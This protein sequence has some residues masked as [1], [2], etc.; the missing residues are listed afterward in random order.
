MGSKLSFR[1][2]IDGQLWARVKIKQRPDLFLSR[3]SIFPPAYS[4]R[5]GCCSSGKKDLFNVR[6]TSHGRVWREVLQ[7]G[8]VSS[9]F[10]FRLRHVVQPVLDRAL[11]CF[12]EVVGDRGGYRRGRP[13]P[14]LTRT[15][16]VG[17]I[18]DSSAI[19]SA[20]TSD[21]SSSRSST[22]GTTSSEPSLDD[23]R[24]PIC[25]SDVGSESD[26]SVGVSRGESLLDDM[27]GC[28]DE[29]MLRRAGA[30][31]GWP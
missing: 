11:A 20:F 1:A 22:L 13:R 19:G 23:R 9:H 30:P 6:V 12:A 5:N 7:N 17:E 25:M 4:L 8:L 28:G 16:S 14:R 31:S 26:S 15:G 24:E 10:F 18:G 29:E 21:N 3:F 2:V 27:E